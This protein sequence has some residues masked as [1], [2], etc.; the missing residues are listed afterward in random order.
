ML[1]NQKREKRS[2]NGRPNGNKP[3]AERGGGVSGPSALVAPC[4]KP[5]AASVR[6]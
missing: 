5:A 3:C 4:L 6:F 1:I 2:K